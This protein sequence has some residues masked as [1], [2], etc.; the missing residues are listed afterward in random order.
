M[1][2]G[3]Q[4]DLDHVNAEGGVNGQKVKLLVFDD[5]NDPKVAQQKATE[6][7]KSTPALAVLATADRVTNTND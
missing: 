2:Q 3:V 6:I 5:R 1:V 4:L 7:V